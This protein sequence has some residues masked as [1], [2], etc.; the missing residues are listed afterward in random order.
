MTLICFDFGQSYSVTN[1][2]A[3]GRYWVPI[4]DWVAN[5]NDGMVSS[6]VDSANQVLS[7]VSFSMLSKFSSSGPNYVGTDSNPW[8]P[9][10]AT[11]DSMFGNVAA[12]GGEA[13]LTPRFRL[14]GL[15]DTRAY[16]FTFFGSRVSA[17]DNREARY[18]VEGSNSGYADLDASNNV[19]N[20]V[21]VAG[22]YPKNGGIMI[23]LSPGPN[24]NN[25]YQFFYLC[26]MLVNWEASS[27]FTPIIFQY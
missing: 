7:G 23:S 24:N 3:Q 25:A 10:W 17:S 9:T 5:T 8:Y 20:V 18:T 11:Q 4:P 6:L 1:P 13:N 22:I 15:D 12:Y 14:S 16:D 2:D 26:F 21:V 27:K 19:S